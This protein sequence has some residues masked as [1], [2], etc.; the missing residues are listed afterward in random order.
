MME[1]TARINSN[2]KRL[3]FTLSL[4]VCHGNAI[5]VYPGSNDPDAFF[6]SLAMKYVADCAGISLQNESPSCLEKGMNHMFFGDTYQTIDKNINTYPGSRRLRNVAASLRQKVE[7]IVNNGGG[8]P[9]FQQRHLEYGDATHKTFGADPIPHEP[10]ECEAPKVEEITIQFVVE[11]A[12]GQCLEEGITVSD[13]ASEASIQTFADF[14]GAEQCWIEL[15]TEDASMAI[16]AKWMNDCA[17][18]DLPFFSSNQNHEEEKEPEAIIDGTIVGCMLNYA[19]SA[20]WSDFGLL[21][22]EQGSL[23]VCYPPGHDSVVNICPQSIAPSALTKCLGSNGL[24]KIPNMSFNYG[25]M[26]MPMSMSFDYEKFDWDTD[27]FF[28]GDEAYYEGFGKFFEF[29]S[30]GISISYSY[31][32]RGRVGNA[33]M[34]RNDPDRGARLTEDF[35][36]LLD[37]LRSNQG[38][39]CLLPICV[40]DTDE[41]DGYADHA[42]SMAPSQGPSIIPSQGI[43]TT[44]SQLPSFFPSS[45]PSIISSIAPSTAPSI[46]SSV[47]STQNITYGTLELRYEASIKVKYFN[48]VDIPASPGADLDALLQ[49][50]REGIRNFL[51]DTADAHVLRIGTNVFAKLHRIRRYRNLQ[52][53]NDNVTATGIDGSEELEIDF[54]VTFKLHCK[55]TD[56]K[57][58][59]KISDDAYESMT[60]NIGQAVSDG[61]LTTVMQSKANASG[62]QSLATIE[63]E[64]S[65]FQAGE[66]IVTVTLAENGGGTDSSGYSSCMNI[67]VAFIGI[68][69]SLG[70]LVIGQSL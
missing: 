10:G 56:C 39:Q 20:P 28:E 61:S 29:D 43:P 1:N 11:V 36:S 65:S 16:I 9:S 63:V 62:V 34:L 21:E 52:T 19:M 41:L 66:A 45:A 69:A 3:G 38:K 57:E 46:M 49:V 24:P 64:P 14:F 50:L 23:D 58:A 2:R 47:N 33:D 25:D 26:S 27:F 30:Q 44:S 8:P 31:N 13:E 60:L 70:V 5:Q 54:E 40:F 42:P 48:V 6:Q 55:D 37:E 59:D 18:I 17:G 7:R 51:P 68:I 15:C 35:C 32:T 12:K 22:P 4:L 53:T 67:R